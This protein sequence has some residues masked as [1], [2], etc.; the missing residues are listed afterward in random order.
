[1]NVTNSGYAVVVPIDPILELIKWK[2][3]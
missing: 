3:S 1:M 2:K